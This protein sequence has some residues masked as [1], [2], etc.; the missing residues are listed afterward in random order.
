MGLSCVF[1]IGSTTKDIKPQAVLLESGDVALMSKKSRVCYH[2]VPRVFVNSFK[3]SAEEEKSLD[4]TENG[5]VNNELHC[6]NY[7]KEHRINF[8]FRQ[9]VFDPEE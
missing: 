1:L 8:N 7:L 9:V 3:W 2:G 4:R 6:Y 5:K